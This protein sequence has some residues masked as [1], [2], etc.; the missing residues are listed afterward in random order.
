MKFDPRMSFWFGVLTSILIAVAGGTIKLTNLVPMD[1]QPTI[2][3]WAALFAF[4]NNTILT[5]LHGFSSSSPGPLV[6]P[7]DAAP[8]PKV[9]P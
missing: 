9:G 3:A 4:V 5:A 2:I 8:V 6:S 1:W 7:P